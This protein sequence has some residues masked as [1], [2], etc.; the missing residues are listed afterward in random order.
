MKKWMSLAVTACCAGLLAGCCALCGKKECP[1]GV[2]AVKPDAAQAAAVKDGSVDT[3]ALMAMMRAKTV[4]TVLDAR[5]GAYD[6]GNRLPGAKSLS[7]E[8]PAEKIAAVLP[9]KQALVVTYC[10]NV[11]CPASGLLAKR[12]R[13]LGYSNVLEYHEGIA[14]WRAAGNAVERAAP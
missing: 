4:M 3:A 6:D 9:D 12:L 14:G 10:G 2:C 1:L 8:S 11:K 13:G 7:A 5:T